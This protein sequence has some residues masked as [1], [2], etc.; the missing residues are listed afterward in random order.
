M[1]EKPISFKAKKPSQQPVAQSAP[2]EQEEPIQKPVEQPA[3]VETPTPAPV[4][5]KVAEQPKQEKKEIK[6]SE[7]KKEISVTDNKSTGVKGQLVGGDNVDDF[8]SYWDKNVGMDRLEGVPDTPPSEEEQVRAGK[9]VGQEK[10]DASKVIAMHLGSENELVK[11]FEVIRS[12]TEQYKNFTQEDLDANPELKA[13]VEWW[14]KLKTIVDASMHTD[15]Q[16]LM[17]Q[18]IDALNKHSHYLEKLDKKLGIS[19]M[20]S[21]LGSGGQ[22]KLLSGE[23]AMQLV[24]DRYR[25]LYRVLL[26]NSGFWIKIMPPRSRDIREWLDEVD[27]ERK[28]FGRIIGGHFHLGSNIFLKQKLA[29]LVKMTVVD[30]NLEDWRSGSNL[31]DSI[32]IHDYDTLCWAYSTMI[33]KDGVSISTVCVNPD[34]KNHNKAQFMDLARLSY[35]NPDVYTKEAMQ[36][37]IEG[38]APGVI[39][40]QKDLKYYKENLLKNVRIVTS[41]NKD[42]YELKDPSLGEFIRIGTEFLGKLGSYVKDGD[43][44]SYT[45]ALRKMAMFHLSKMYSAWISKIIINNDNGTIAGIIT[46]K[47]AITASL[48]SLVEDDKNIVKEIEDFIT[49]SKVSYYTATSLRCPKCGH[50]PNLLKDNIFPLDVEYV[51]FCLFYLRLEQVEGGL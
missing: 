18:M 31:V 23:A 50:Q 2:A 51:L 13:T 9:I 47:A 8:P 44:D 15:Q 33:Y 45:T 36:F 46:D 16:N 19:K 49:N 26:H 30:S 25:G 14:S 40:K 21:D 43:T 10:N 6:P 27:F 41:K 20:S 39:R 7:P 11:A 17:M 35:I 28:Q 42:Q 12:Y 4:P 48:E 3:A 38:T 29:D 22:P 37:M 1:N 34:C 24:Q 32:S 5:E